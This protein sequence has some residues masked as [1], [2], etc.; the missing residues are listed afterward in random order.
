MAGG[1]IDLHEVALTE[2]LDA[3]VTADFVP[4][5]RTQTRVSTPRRVEPC[6][7]AIS[8]SGGLPAERQTSSRGSVRGRQPISA[9]GSIVTA[10]K[11]TVRFLYTGCEGAD[12]TEANR[13]VP[14]TQIKSYRYSPGGGQ[15]GA[16]ES[17]QCRYRG[18]LAYGKLSENFTLS[19]CQHVGRLFDNAG[20]YQY[21]PSKTG[22]GAVGKIYTFIAPPLRIWPCSGNRFML[23]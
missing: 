17:G 5:A 6:V 18:W 4:Q 23:Q 9:G 7:G 20:D 21:Q 14:D 13:R 3:A 19:G 15:Q 12:Y 10:A 22:L 8:R 16:C 2:A 1:T 11:D